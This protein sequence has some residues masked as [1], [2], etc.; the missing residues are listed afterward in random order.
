MSVTYFMFCGWQFSL[1]RLI[2]ILYM[3]LSH[4]WVQQKDLTK[5]LK[6]GDKQL[7]SILEFLQ[8]EKLI[9]AET[10]TK[11]YVVPEIVFLF[12]CT[13]FHVYGVM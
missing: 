6:M 13:H 12:Q 2:F 5:E 4:V 10:A 7:N 9:Q 1:Y 11:V 3:F 8:E